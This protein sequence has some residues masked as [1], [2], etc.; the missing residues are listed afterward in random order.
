M[1]LFSAL[2]ALAQAASFPPAPPI[3]VRTWVHGEPVEVS[4]E[5]VVV[6]ELWATWCG[7]CLEQLPHLEALRDT[8]KG[9]ADFVAVSDERAGVVASFWQEQGWL[10]GFSVGVDPSGQTTARYQRVDGASGIPRAYIVHDGTVAWAGHPAVLDAP[11]AAIV[12]DRWDPEQAAFAA[13]IGSHLQG[14][15]RA[16]EAGKGDAA[17]LG[18]EIV[19]HAVQLPA[20]L[21]ELAWNILTALPPEQRDR[22]LAL[23]AARAAVTAAPG[24]AAYLDTLGL[25]LFE[26]G[27]QTEAIDVQVRAVGACEV[28]EADFCAELKA[29]LRTFRER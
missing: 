23:A 15:F 10:P 12:S 27:E 16:A 18:A 29:R 14:Y 20:A 4:G 22:T 9:R 26:N 13:D 3:G 21:N 24:E 28:E 6:V 8:Y 5:G 25:A 19:R 1:V 17:A 11:L 2:L 7:P